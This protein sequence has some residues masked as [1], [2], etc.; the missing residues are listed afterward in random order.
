MSNLGGW[1][2]RPNLSVRVFQ[3]MK[4]K[5]DDIA[6]GR[7]GSHVCALTTTRVCAQNLICF[8]M[9]DSN[10]IYVRDAMTAKPYGTPLTGLASPARYLQVVADCRSCA[11]IL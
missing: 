2:F 7:D 4:R 9:S 5:K 11:V 3:C 1:P 10:E 6:C 8:A